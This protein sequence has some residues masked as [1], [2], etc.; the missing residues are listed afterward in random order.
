MK[1]Q[2]TSYFKVLD[3]NVTSF[4]STYREEAAA[5]LLT[6]VIGNDGCMITNPHKTTM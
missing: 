6:V 5:L 3:K 1:K 4:F 2:S